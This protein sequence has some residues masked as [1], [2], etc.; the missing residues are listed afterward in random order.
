MKTIGERAVQAI[1]DRAKEKG[2]K[3]S[4]AYKEIGVSR[5]TF[6]GWCWKGHTPSTYYLQQ[7]AL[8]GYDVHWILTGGQ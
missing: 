8:F 6:Y 5:E 2:T 7:M 3:V 4:T 1:F